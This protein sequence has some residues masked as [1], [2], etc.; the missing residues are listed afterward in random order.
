MRLQQQG[1]EKEIVRRNKELTALSAVAAALSRS[2][3]L[4]DMLQ[5]ALDA[6]LDALELEAGAIY[7]LDEKRHELTFKTGR[8]VPT[9]A[10]ERSRDSDVWARF[11]SRV[12][13]SGGA[14]VMD[15][16]RDQPESVREEARE[17]GFET[18][19][20][21][22]LRAKGVTVGVVEFA[23][24]Q[25]RPFEEDDLQLLATMGSQIAVAIQ[26]A[27]L[28]EQ[29]E[30][31]L[32]DL[33]RLY[34]VAADMVSTL[35]LHE[36]LR[37]IVDTA[38]EVIPTAD[39]A[40]IHL[41]DEETGLLVPRVP[42]D[43]EPD[44]LRRASMHVGEGIAGLV[45]QE[46]KTIYVPDIREDPRYLDLGSDIQS[47]LVAPLLI[48]EKLVGTLTV[49]STQANA[50]NR[51]NERM[52]TMLASQAAVAIENAQ[53]YE[54]L[55]ESEERYRAYVENVPDA[56]WETDA[57]NRFTYWS[58]QIENLT[59]YAPQELLGQTPYEGLIHPADVKEFSNRIQQTVE[60]ERQEYTLT[61]RAFHRDGSIL[62]LETSIRAVRHDAGSI[63]KFQGVLRDVSERVRLQ[64]QLLH[65]EKMA[66]LGRLGASIAH[67]I[68]NPLQSVQ[69]CLTL[70]GEE[71]QDRQRPDKLNQYLGVVGSEI[72]RISAIV[73][74]MR[75]FYR[76]E[77][78]GVQPTSLH[79]VLA[80]VLGLA[81]KQ[82]QHSNVAV[83]RE[84]TEELPTIQANPDHLKQVFLNLVLNAID[85]MPGGGTLRISTAEDRVEAARG[86]RSLPAVRV[87]FSDTGEGMPPEILSRIF[88]PFFTTREEGT[89][90]GLS[91]SYGIIESHNGH[92]SATSQVGVGTTFT[93]LLPVE[94]P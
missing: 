81:G 4:G 72:E 41:L 33:N 16:T 3:E 86:E 55:R 88:E 50:F 60:E 27:T 34:R 10:E 43:P 2:P 71:L 89:G 74:R 76:P 11:A 31:R 36:V 79:A 49:D 80:S 62:Q 8:G 93:I 46:R 30:Q 66:A 14:E 23:T 82:L 39:K 5:G 91:I 87:E 32:G 54:R 48:E 37:S 47:L 57:K 42:S 69:N 67:E 9:G 12:V 38:Q 53:L 21:V 7:L 94:Q 52:L 65:S 85:A 40:M 45:S 17:A 28:V 15:D 24:S 20:G 84:L 6:V 25:P 44:P 1:L 22:P 77:H 70:L 64:T 56:I 90:L 73:S 68:N 61:H 63:V 58:P 78:R 18:M 29:A 26:N 92:I 83:E 13:Q 19:V 51:D 59:G 75:S 35:D